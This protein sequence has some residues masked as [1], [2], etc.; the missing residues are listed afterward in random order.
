MEIMVDELRVLGPPHGVPAAISGSCGPKDPDRFGQQRAR[1]GLSRKKSG[2][3]P[4]CFKASESNEVA[5]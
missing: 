4:K 2:K 3:H 5:R 1:R